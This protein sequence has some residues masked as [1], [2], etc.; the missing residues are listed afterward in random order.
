VRADSLRELALELVDRL[1]EGSLDRA[2]KL[3]VRL[4]LAAL[5]AAAIAAKRGRS[6]AAPLFA[7]SIDGRVMRLDVEGVGFAATWQFVQCAWGAQQKIL[8]IVCPIAMTLGSIVRI[9][10]LST[11]CEQLNFRTDL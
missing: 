10:T 9:A 6:I 11:G 7:A 4:A 3:A 5:L 2:S 1:P 8:S